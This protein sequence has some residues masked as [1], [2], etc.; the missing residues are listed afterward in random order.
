MYMHKQIVIQPYDALVSVGVG[1]IESQLRTLKR[2]YGIVEH[3]DDTWLGLCNHQYSEKLQ[4]NVF[5]IIISSSNTDKK[6]YWNT[7]SHEMS[8]LVQEILEHKSIFFHRGKANEPYAYLN[9]Y[10]MGELFEFF[11]KEYIKIKV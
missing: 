1:S 10:L 9:G 7:I 11:E 3:A 4:R 5:Y 8:H 2:K 6:K